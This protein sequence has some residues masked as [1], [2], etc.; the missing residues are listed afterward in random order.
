[1][2]LHK[3]R[4]VE[5]D[6]DQARSK[7]LSIFDEARGFSEIDFNLKKEELAKELKKEIVSEKKTVGVDVKIEHFLLNPTI[8]SIVEEKLKIAFSN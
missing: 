8:V 7:V 4:R 6:E 3:P 1:V 2:L 5:I